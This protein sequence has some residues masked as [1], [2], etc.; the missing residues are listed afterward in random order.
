VKLTDDRQKRYEWLLTR[1]PN[2]R[3]CLL[4]VLRLVEDQEGEINNDGMMLAAE[5]CEV[6]PAHVLGVVTFYTHYR[7]A[8]TGK[9]CVQVCATLPCSLRGAGAVY[10]HLSGKLGISSGQTTADGMF[11]LRKVECLA[12][13]G[14]APCVQIN[15][16]YHENLSLEDVD[17]IIDGLS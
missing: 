2:K 10:D 7:R 6:S 12:S 3:A 16:D 9:Y 17:R 13:C 4:P 8:G 11:T 14:T 5:L 15:D 1:Y